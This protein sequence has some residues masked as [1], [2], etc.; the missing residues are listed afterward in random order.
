MDRTTIGA[1]ATP[2]GYGGIGIIRLSGPRAVEIA[3]SV[4]RRG[5]R[6]RR[7][8]CFSETCD[9][10][11]L[12]SWRLYYGH[13]VEPSEGRVLDEVLLAVMRAPRSYTCEDVVEIHAHSGPK[14]LQSILDLL[15]SGGARIA[16]PGEF[17]RRAYMNGRID[18]TQAEAVADL[19][20]ASSDSALDMAVAQV[21]GSLN[22]YIS[23]IRDSLMSVLSN[24]EAAVD[25]PDAV[26]DEID[27]QDIAVKLSKNVLDPVRR[28]IDLYESGRYLRRGLRVVIVGGPNAGKSSL[29]NRLVNTEKSIVT[30]TPGTTRDSIEASMIARGFSFVLADTAGIREN[31]DPLERLGIE[32][33]M[34]QVESADIALFV[35]DLSRPASAHDLIVFRELPARYRILVL[36]KSDLSENQKVFALPD[37][38]RS[39]PCFSVS[40][41]YGYGVSDLLEELTRIAS[42]SRESANSGF[43]P[44]W[45]QKTLLDKIFKSVSQAVGCLDG[46]QA[47]EL[48][49]I[50]LRD[51]VETLDEITGRYVSV[52]VLDRVFNDFCVGK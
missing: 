21:A 4:F 9:P 18:L 34:E 33:T 50:D 49:S 23:P 51:A 45:R 24:I 31:P 48:V 42:N 25:F 32:K 35:F 3:C 16:Q 22:T 44:N 2:E 5:N 7:K 6:V 27:S 30:E 47:Y 17:T 26:G 46:K 15:L 8:D 41:M 40:A 37:E 43:V 28:L 20:N 29:M 12:E 39:Y 1:I 13:I 10:E 36:N 38:L 11:S 52:D 14:V 19:I